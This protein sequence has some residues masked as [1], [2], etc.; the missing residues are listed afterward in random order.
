MDFVFTSGE[1]EFHAQSRCF[2][3]RP[4]KLLI[5]NT[6]SPGATFLITL[7]ALRNGKCQ[8]T[9]AVLRAKN[10]RQTGALL[11]ARNDR[12]PNTDAGP[13]TAV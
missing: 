11:R 10:S 3:W 9:L 7:N 6:P 8:W 1:Q 4:L 13:V 12:D 5:K 2:I